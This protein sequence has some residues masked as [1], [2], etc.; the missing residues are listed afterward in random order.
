M[1]SID[2]WPFWIAI[3]VAGGPILLSFVSIMLSL[4]LSHR[5]KNAMIEALR[6]S[7]YI[8]IL[9]SSLRNQSWYGDVMMIAKIAGMVI[10]SKAYIRIGD[11]SPVDIE[12]F[13]AHLKRLLLINLVMVFGALTWMVVVA[14]LLKFR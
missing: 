8:Y 10:W 1:T 2:T 7:R 4:Y 14:L 3:F 9:E 6:N 13:P 12:N 5:Y 11:V